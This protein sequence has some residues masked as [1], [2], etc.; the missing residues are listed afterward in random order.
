LGVD[1]EVGDVAAGVFETG[2]A[3]ELE[4]VDCE[5]DPDTEEE[6]EAAEDADEAA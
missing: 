6:V 2:D 3:S 4:D 1:D 5:F